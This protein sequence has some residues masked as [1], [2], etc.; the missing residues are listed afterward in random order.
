[1]VGRVLGKFQTKAIGKG[2]TLLYS[3]FVLTPTFSLGVEG[4]ET[5]GINRTYKLGK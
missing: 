4:L 2:W 3:G 1:M 5:E